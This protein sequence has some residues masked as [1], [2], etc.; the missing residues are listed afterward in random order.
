MTTSA[1]M[2]TSGATSASY[3]NP[4]IWSD[5]IEQV[6]REAS[7]FPALG[8]IDNRAL[9]TSGVQINI[10]KNQAFTAAA[11]TEGVATPVT[12]MA[13]DQVTVTFAEYGLAKQ[14]S[15]LQLAYGLKGVFDDITRNMGL[16]L[17]EKRDSVI[18][19]A[20]SAG[21][22]NTLYADGVTSGSI[23]SANVFDTDLIANGKTTIRLQ[24]RMA[25]YLVVHPACENS[26]LKDTQFVDASEYGG[27]EVVLN[28]EIGKYLG[29]KVISS[30]YITSAT[31]NS[32][33][34]Y[35]NLMLADR[36]YVW[37]PKMAP[38]VVWKEDSVLDRAITF[39]ADEAY[40]VKVL[41]SESICVLKST[42]GI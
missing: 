11:L 18:V 37:A 38:R 4:Q 13:F 32:V 3:L 42:G 7:V 5:Q 29:M 22:A 33:T 39:A 35:Q 28:G 23:T 2:F 41:N 40:G 1:N 16:A 14:I 10:A 30:A 17:A 19:T 20:A 26:L 9:G 31:E 8:V 27:R 21:A 34:V 12:T 25:K 36:P 6:A 15:M 24:K